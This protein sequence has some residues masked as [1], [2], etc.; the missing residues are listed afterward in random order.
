[1]SAKQTS[2]VQTVRILVTCLALTAI[3][4]TPRASAEQ[5]S[6]TANV[7]GVEL[8]TDTPF[9]FIAL[10]DTLKNTGQPVGLRLSH[11][12]QLRG[13]ETIHFQLSD[14][15]PAVKELHMERTP[16]VELLGRQGHRLTNILAE[17][18]DYQ[19]EVFVGEQLLF[20]GSLAELIEH[21]K[22]LLSGPI[23][24]ISIDSQWVDLAPPSANKSCEDDCYDD[25]YD[26]IDLYCYGYYYNSYMCNSGCEN[27]YEDCLEDEC[28][29]CVD[30]VSVTTNSVTELLSS[31]TYSSSCYNDHWYPGSSTAWP[32]IYNY[33]WYSYKKT[34]T[35]TTTYCDGSVVVEVIDTEYW[36]A[37]CNQR[38]WSTCSFPQG[39]AYPVCI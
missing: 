11:N 23:A 18:D 37:A 22:S 32:R 30:P 8:S 2:R 34:T 4:V 31:G 10:P 16:A 3:V 5:C 39:S 7:R 27:D 25:F 38:T 12:G 28:G 15:E 17:A 1:M 9:L 6:L 33:N 29:V 26:C 36:T 21:S 35:R 14:S 24:P 19:A 13:V 20:S